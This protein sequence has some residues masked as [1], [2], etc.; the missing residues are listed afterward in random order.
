M[1]A[2]SRTPDTNPLTEPMCQKRSFLSQALLTL[3]SLKNLV[4]QTLGETAFGFVTFLAALKKR[5][6]VQAAASGKLGS[7]LPFAAILINDRLAPALRTQ[8]RTLGQ[9][10]VAKVGFFLATDICTH[11]TPHEKDPPHLRGT[12]PKSDCCQSYSSA[13]ASAGALAASSRA[14]FLAA[15][16]S[17]RA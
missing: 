14:A 13:A 1:A 5:S 9:L 7:D 11:P 3:E 16:S 17:T 2:L 12:G 6:L 4:P 10:S 8:R 15:F